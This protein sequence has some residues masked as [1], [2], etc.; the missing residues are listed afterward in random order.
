MFSLDPD[1]LRT[2]LAISETGSFGGAGEKVNKTQSTVS[3]QMKRLE[4]IVGVPLFEKEGRRNVLTADGLKL[5][6]YAASMVRLNDEAIRAFRPPEVSGRVRLGAIDEYAQAFLPAI[7]RAFNLAHPA[8]QVEVATGNTGH[9][10]DLLADRQLDAAILSCRAGDTEIEVLRSDRLHWFGSDVGSPH[11]DDPLPFCAWSSGCSWREMASAAL[12][13]DGRK[14]RLVVTT[15]NAAL[16]TLTVR[17]GLGVAVAPAWFVSPGLRILEEMDARYP[18]G[19]AEIGIKR[20]A[21]AENPVRELFLSY[22]KAQL[23]SP[24][25]A[26]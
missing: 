19:V 9:L 26:A 18:L 3:A 4:E 2:F 5:L 16:I 25:L 7:L 8:V 11:F 15:S 22:A 17:D 24:A 20:A 10:L 12:A 13:R 1:F 21:G 6:E 23:G 14:S